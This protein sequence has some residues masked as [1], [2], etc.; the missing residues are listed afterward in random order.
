MLTIYVYEQNRKA[1]DAPEKRVLLWFALPCWVPAKF[2]TLVKSSIRN[3][4]WNYL[5][6]S[7]T[8]LNL[9]SHRQNQM[10]SVQSKKAKIIMSVCLDNLLVIN[11]NRRFSSF[12][13][14]LILLLSLEAK[15]F[16]QIIENF[17]GS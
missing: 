9:F 7:Q 3:R 15:Y 11:L 8:F 14:N 12:I 16:T 10:K 2:F 1:K 13:L 4:I 6:D 17:L 5:T